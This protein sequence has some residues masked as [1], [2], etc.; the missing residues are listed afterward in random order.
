M[1]YS[2]MVYGI[3][4]LMNDTLGFD[5]MN[6]NGLMLCMVETLGYLFMFI[7]GYRFSRKMI[8]IVSYSGIAT[9]GVFLLVLGLLKNSGTSLGTPDD[10]LVFKIFETSTLFSYARTISRT[11]IHIIDVLYY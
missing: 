8:H 10:S 2:Y 7:F 11:R 5:S 3:S 9:F 4:T 1:G 6:L